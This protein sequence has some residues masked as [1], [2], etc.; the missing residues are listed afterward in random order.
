M[1]LCPDKYTL[2]HVNVLVVFFL[3][4]FFLSLSFF[5]L[6]FLN[7]LCC[8]GEKNLYGLRHQVQGRS[9]RK[10]KKSK[11]FQ[12]R[13]KSL[14][15]GEGLSIED[16]PNL[17][18]MQSLLCASMLWCWSHPRCP[19]I[20]FQVTF[21]FIPKYLHLT[22]PWGRAELWHIFFL[23]QKISCWQHH[24]ETFLRFFFPWAKSH[25]PFA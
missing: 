25:L 9:K 8:F 21:F 10:G 4:L 23:L 20:F 14:W 5:S 1:H 13:R 22:K 18:W 3:P 16:N 11:L 12:R 24:N 19:T 17:P 7:S 6:F 2:V 15:K